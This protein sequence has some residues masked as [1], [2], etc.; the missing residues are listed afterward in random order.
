MAAPAELFRCGCHGT[1]V[2]DCL[3]IDE[4]ESEYTCGQ[5]TCTCTKGWDCFAMNLDLAAW[6]LA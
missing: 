3:A 2:T 1:L 6:A 5:L 4:N